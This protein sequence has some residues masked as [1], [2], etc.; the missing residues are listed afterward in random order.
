MLFFPQVDLSG[1]GFASV[2]I[3]LIEGVCQ[4]NPANKKGTI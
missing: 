4:K 2:D 3:L 1:P